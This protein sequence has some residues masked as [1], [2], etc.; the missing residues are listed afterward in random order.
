MPNVQQAISANNKRI[1]RTK[2]SVNSR[3]C[4]CRNQAEC[5]LDGKCLTSSLIYQASVETKGNCSTYIGSCEGAFKTRYANH[6][7]TFKHEQKRNATELSKFVWNLKDSRVD[8]KIKWNILYEAKPYNNTSDRCKLCL[9]EK[10]FIVYRHDLGTLNK[11]TEM[12]SVCRH[13]AKFLL[14]NFVT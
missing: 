4:N 3:Q 9:L 8:F 13:K 2:K 5:P 7:T 6:K 1:L 11:R 10:Y 12:F 14:R